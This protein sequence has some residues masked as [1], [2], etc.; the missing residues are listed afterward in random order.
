MGRQGT[1]SYAID[2]AHLA[3]GLVQLHLKTKV[4]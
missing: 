2:D 3:R 1:F 4:G